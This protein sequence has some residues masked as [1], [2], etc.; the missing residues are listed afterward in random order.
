MTQQFPVPL[1]QMKRRWRDKDGG[2]KCVFVL[3]G[4]V[5]L[6]VWVFVGGGS[7]LFLNRN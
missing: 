2:V 5:C 1:R 7:G 6:L 3:F 4:S